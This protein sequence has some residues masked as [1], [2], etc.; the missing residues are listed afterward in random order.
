MQLNLFNEPPKV[1]CFLLLSPPEHIKTRIKQQKVYL[2]KKIGLSRENRYALAHISLF[3]LYTNEND[4][5][6]V[7]TL[8]SALSDQGSFDI[9][10]HGIEYLMHGA[11]SFSVCVKIANSTPITALYKTLTEVFRTKKVYYYPHLTI[12][13]SITI[14]KYRM[15]S[16]IYKYVAIKEDFVCNVVSVLKRYLDEKKP[17]RKIYQAQLN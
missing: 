4:R 9:K 3:K 12:A 17:Y 16:E 14:N 6:I 15:V 2:A 11:V 10:L 7:N 8:K 13:R 5:A 1:E